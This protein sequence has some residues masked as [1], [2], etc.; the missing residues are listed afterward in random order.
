VTRRDPAERQSPEKTK[1]Q[2]GP[3]AGLPAAAG[4]QH[5]GSELPAGGR[6]LRSRPGERVA[7]SVAT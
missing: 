4:L 6:E 1:G 7:E 5:E 2:G 3:W